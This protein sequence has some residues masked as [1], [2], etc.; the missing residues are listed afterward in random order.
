MSDDR[1]YLVTRSFYSAGHPHLLTGYRH[2]HMIPTGVGVFYERW[3]ANRAGAVLHTRAEAVEVVARL[4]NDDPDG[5]DFA[6][7]ALDEVP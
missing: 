1:R 7:V 5:Y 2:L 6:V 4:Q 3:L